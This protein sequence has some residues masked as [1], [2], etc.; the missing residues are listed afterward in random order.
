MV[1]CI[2]KLGKSR[3]EVDIGKVVFATTLN[4]ISNTVFSVD[5]VDPDSESAQEF[6]DLIWTIMEDAGKPNFSDYLPVLRR[7]DVQGIKRHIQ[8][9]Y[10]RLHEIFD[11]LIDR[12][13]ESRGGS[14]EKKEGVDFLDVL[15]DQCDE[16]G[17][18]FTRHTI[19]PIIVDLFIAGSDTSAITTEWAM[20]E[21]LHNPTLLQ[22]A[23][24]EIIQTVGTQEPVKETDV[25]RLP[26]LQAIVKETMR[27]HPAV[28]LLL[29]HRAKNDVDLF[30]FTIPKDTQVL[31][32]AWA[33]GR[34]S[35]D[36][37]NP[38][39]F[40]PERFLGSSRDYKGRHFEYLPFG[41]GRRICP[42][43]PLAARM[44]HLLLAS[45]LQSNDW[46]LPEGTNVE[47]M[48]MD[49]KFGVSLKK[50]LPLVLVPICEEKV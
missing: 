23:R 17:L 3:K 42:G 36:W 40:V 7:L 31:V 46:K 16:N 12:R 28:P 2:R 44:I 4:L 18:E 34:D 8:P 14:G 15:L 38:T 29:P 25:N 5:L 47:N 30:G 20:A 1:S 49:E 26:Y 19:K 33:I 32:N 35:K 27:L 48:N 13:L 6:K 50:A 21:L 45:L 24:D 22:K 39:S 37:E 43:I 11:E 9:A 10:L 41:A